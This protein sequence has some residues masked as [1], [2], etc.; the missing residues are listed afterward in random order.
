MGGERSHH[1]NNNALLAL[2]L[3]DTFTWQVTN[4]SKLKNTISLK[5]SQENKRTLRF[6]S[7]SPAFYVQNKIRLKDVKR[8]VQTQRDRP[9][10]M[11]SRYSK[12]VNDQNVRYIMKLQVGQKRDTI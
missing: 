2:T 7:Y 5:L 6:S 4:C 9:N 3:K 12:E 10:H 11:S 8:T 1:Y